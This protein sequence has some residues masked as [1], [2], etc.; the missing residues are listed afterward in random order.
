MEPEA[1]QA[2]IAPDGPEESIA[3]LVDSI[4]QAPR[5]RDDLVAL[6]PEN[7]PLYAGRGANATV[8]L[9]GYIL[10]AFEDVGLPAA[11]LPYVLDELQ[12]S[13]DAYVTAAAAK[14]LR[15]L[16][17][18]SPEVVPYLLRAFD[19]VRYLDDAISFETY[20][21]RWPLRQRTT[22]LEEIF[23]TFASLGSVARG[24][25]SELEA[26]HADTLAPRAQAALTAAI[27][28]IAGSE[29]EDCCCDEPVAIEVQ[30]QADG[31]A[32]PPSGVVLQDQDGRLLTYAEFFSQ[33]PSIVVFFY[34]R[35]DNPNKCSLS[36]A[37]LAR[38]QHAIVTQGLAGQ[39]KTAAITYDFGFDLPPR[40]RAYGE[41]RG[42]AF[43]DH[44]RFFR[45]PTDF[46]TVREY[47]ALGVNFGD[48]LVNRHRIELYVLDESGRIVDSFTR[49]QWEPSEVLNR[50]RALLAV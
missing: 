41:N 6:L 46:A 4:R 15:G 16:A 23:K 11:A 48:V 22:A 7:H 30:T 32:G 38:L 1:P 5:R 14:A 43:D 21:P 19:N 2:T 3:A 26:L 12:N 24:A 29:A 35:C 18:P 17:Q 44:N 36:I 28:T 9:R 25:L 33:S 34:T 49:L 31:R 45:T 50:A 10:A 47:F 13:R 20:K 42:V 37:K 27:E 39:L 8:R 40:L